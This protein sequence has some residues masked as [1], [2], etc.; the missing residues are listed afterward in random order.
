MRNII[1][2]CALL[3][4]G[5]T[6]YSTPN[7]MLAQEFKGQNISG[8]AMSEKLDGVRAYWDGKQLISRQGRLFTPPKGY[9]QQ[10]PPYHI[11]GELYSGRGQFEQISATVRQSSASWSAIK[12]NVFDVPQAKGNLYQRLAVLQ[13]WL[14]AHPKAPIVIVKQIPARDNAHAFAFLKEIEAKGG[15]GVMLHNPNI[16][17]SNGR[18]AN[19]LKLK[20]AQDEECT[21]TQH[22]PGKGKYVGKLGAVSCKNERGEFRIGSGFKDIDRTNPPPIGS[23]ITYKYRG[24]TQKGTPRFATF[25][26]RYQP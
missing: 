17:Y 3:F 2:V 5:Q 23:Q 7:V 18:T 4:I 21:V 16:P 20:T 6:A 14:N 22:H 24:F 15:E 25:L 10:F 9:T 1:P 11:D 26:R 19:L 8:W 13:N 12:L